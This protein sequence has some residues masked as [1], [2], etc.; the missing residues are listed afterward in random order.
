MYSCIVEL[1]TRVT[2]GTP[3]RCLLALDREQDWIP[4][5]VLL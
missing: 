4:L 5:Y 2:Y 3:R 1:E